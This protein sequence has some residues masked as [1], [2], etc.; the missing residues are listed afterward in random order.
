MPALAEQPGTSN[1]DE[2]RRQAVA[3]VLGMAPEQVQAPTAT[4]RLVE[5]LGYDSLRL[6]ELAI[7]VESLFGIHA[8]LEQPVE[9]QTLADVEQLVM[10]LA[11]AHSLAT[12]GRP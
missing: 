10:Q 11:Q 5:D 8:P 12:D 1:S 3:L 2:V 6:I 7:A 9:A 4:T